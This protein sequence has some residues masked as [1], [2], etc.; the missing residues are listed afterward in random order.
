MNSLVDVFRGRIIEWY[1]KHG[2]RELPW[3]STGDPWAILVAA[4]MLRRTTTRQVLRVYDEFIKRYPQPELLLNTNLAE[5]E[6]LI[7]PL[8][9]RS[10]TRQLV[11][12]AGYIV[13]KLGGKIPC[14]REVLK[15]LPGIGDYALSEVL[16]AYCNEPVPLLDT[17]MVRVLF[18]V[19]GVKPAKLPP[20]R[21]GEYREFVKYLVPGNPELAKCFNYGVLDFAR[22]VCTARRPRCGACILNDI[23]IHAGSKTTTGHQ[24]SS[25]FTL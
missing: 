19:F 23:C 15:R 25:T 7:R 12:L 8:G 9:L 13:K 18:R 17:N 6:L 10:R 24:F 5:I 21:D 3:R 14:S 20:Y 22:K 1:W 2:Q 11:E 4:V 16:L